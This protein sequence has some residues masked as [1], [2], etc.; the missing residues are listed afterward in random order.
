MPSIV[1]DWEMRV[2]WR[3]TKLQAWRHSIVVENVSAIFVSVSIPVLLTVHRFSLF[4]LLL[5]FVKAHVPSISL[6]FL[7]SG[8]LAATTSLEFLLCLTNLISQRVWILILFILILT[9][10][11]HCHINRK[12]SKINLIHVLVE[13]LDIFRRRYPLRRSA[14]SYLVSQFWILLSYILSFK[15]RKINVVNVLL[16]IFNF[17]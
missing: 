3:S 13:A 14:P 6:V 5:L 7:I 4:H 11:A 2:A 10:L 12:V 17:I 15:N 8:R 9:I 16:K 1:F